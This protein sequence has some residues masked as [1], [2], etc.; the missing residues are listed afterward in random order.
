MEIKLTGRRALVT[1][2]NSGIGEVIALALAD[3]GAKVAVNYV[4]D[5]EAARTVAGKIRDKSSDALALDAD[6]SNAEQVEQMFE[7]IDSAWGGL[8]VLVNNAGI[9]GPRAYGWE[10]DPTAWG[11]V[12]D[13]NLLGAF[14]CSREALRRM[15][16]QKNGVSG[17]RDCPQGAC[18]RRERNCRQTLSGAF[19]MTYE[20]HKMRWM[21]PRERIP[22]PFAAVSIRLIRGAGARPSER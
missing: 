12:I 2:A 22:G 4:V 17:R 6:V 15:V 5:P 20:P 16:P 10:S 13:I 14:H 11:R 9:D 1:G 8:D 18:W 19:S 21:L 3:A 7:N